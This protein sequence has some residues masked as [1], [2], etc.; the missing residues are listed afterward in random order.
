VMVTEV[1]N[2]PML[3]G[4]TTVSVS[5]GASV[6]VMN[7]AS[8]A[9][10]PANQLTYQLTA[11][12]AGAVISANGVITWTA[13]ANPGPSTNT[14]TTVVTDNGVP[15]ESA[16][17]SIVVVV[18]VPNT[19]PVLPVLGNRVMEELTELVVINTATDADTPASSL[20]YTLQAAPVGAAISATGV[21]TWTPTEGE[22]PSTNTFTTVVTDAGVPA[23][24][25]V[26]SF[27]VVVTEVNASPTLA[28][29][30]DVMIGAGATLTVINTASD[31]D[32]PLNPLTY[33]LTEAPATA[34]IDPKGVLTWTAPLNQGPSTNTFTTVATDHGVPPASA[35][36]SFVVIV[37]NQPPTLPVL[38]QD[39]FLESDGLVVIEAEHYAS[40]TTFSPHAWKPTTNQ[41]GFVG[42]S[43]M[44]AVPD[45]GTN[46]TV[47]P[48]AVS[49]TLR[50]HIQFTTAGPYNY[51]VRGWGDDRSGDSVHV[52]V[53]GQVVESLAYPTTGVWTWKAGQVSID[54]A[55]WH[56]I[57]LWMH[58]DG[59]YV[60]RLLLATNLSFTPTGNG[61]PESLRSPFNPPN[62]P[63]V[64]AITVP[65]SGH[66]IE[67]SYPTDE[68]SIIEFSYDLETW[69]GLNDLTNASL[70]FSESG[71][72]TKARLNLP[73]HSP[74]SLFFRLARPNP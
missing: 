12:P 29:Q 74:G 23:L 17:N 68:L 7:T 46:V 8:D 40:A 9:D 59:A 20:V 70:A 14:F 60:D 44:Q 65:E 13:P 35:T 56:E 31:P 37:T 16:V 39:G 19:A 48:A 24:S 66:S 33:Q 26:N 72:V 4:P 57:N 18:S 6:V 69:A 22:G 21:I 73:G 28:A 38:A 36:N 53:D 5:A 42:E 49:P 45:A 63:P 47:N 58:E 61:P 54:N 62:P 15:P 64:I 11:A 41:S 67:L 51:W 2:A 3:P 50:Y 10:L 52:G 32:L 27:T 25:T 30:P 43:A 1:N 71:G 55:G 34:T